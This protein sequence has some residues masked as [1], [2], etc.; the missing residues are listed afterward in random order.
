MVDLVRHDLRARTNPLDR[1]FVDEEPELRRELSV[2]DQLATGS[3]LDSGAGL[4]CRNGWG[5]RDQRSC[6]VRSLQEAGDDRV[7]EVGDREGGVLV[8]AQCAEL[9]GETVAE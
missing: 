1:V 3:G 5:G 7:L 6:I 9:R 2:E 8:I 4:G